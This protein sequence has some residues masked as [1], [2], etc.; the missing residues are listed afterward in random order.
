MI[1]TT[2]KYAIFSASIKTKSLGINPSRGGAPLKDRK[3]IAKSLF[4]LGLVKE[5][6]LL[7]LQRAKIAHRIS[8]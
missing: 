6:I 2:F 8:A 4:L 5:L 3:E 7:P 1:K